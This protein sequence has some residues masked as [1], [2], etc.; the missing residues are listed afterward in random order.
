MPSGDGMEDNDK[1]RMDAFDETNPA[2]CRM[3]KRRA[4]L[5][6]ASPSTISEKKYGPKLMRYISGEAEALLEPLSPCGRSARR[7]GSC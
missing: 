2:S 1:N 7:G 6:L 4:Q 3:W 5:M